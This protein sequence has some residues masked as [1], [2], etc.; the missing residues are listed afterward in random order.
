VAKGVAMVG[1]LH[2]ELNLEKSKELFYP[3]KI[4]DFFDLLVTYDLTAVVYQ[5][6]R[7]AYPHYVDTGGSQTL[8][9]YETSPWRIDA[10]LVTPVDELLDAAL[11]LHNGTIVMSS[12]E[13]IYDIESK[14]KETSVVD[15]IL[16]L[17]FPQRKALELRAKQMLLKRPFT[18]NKSK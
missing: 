6:A 5:W 2:G 11:Y 7:D 18:L 8:V 10:Y 4:L 13:Y 1:T 15:R 16:T 3:Y 9:G 14:R 17:D 12:Y